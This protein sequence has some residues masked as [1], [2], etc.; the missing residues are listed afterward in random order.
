MKTSSFFSGNLYAAEISPRQ[1]S[2][3][4]LASSLLVKRPSVQVNLDDV[5][6][7]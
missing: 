7:G 1:A 4:D 2:L 3:V 6:A 5:V